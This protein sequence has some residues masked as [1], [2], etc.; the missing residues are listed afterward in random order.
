MYKVYVAESKIHGRGLFAEEDIPPFSMI[1]KIDDSKMISGKNEVSAADSIYCDILTD[2]RMVLMQA[3]EKFTNW[4]E[5]GNYNT[6]PKV[7]NN[8]RYL[9]SLKAI[10]KKE[11]ITCD[12][13]M[14]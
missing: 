5:D 1:L 11:E 10:S 4:S 3:P 8:S 12:L 7:I 2:G 6:I 9:F 14:S 13:M